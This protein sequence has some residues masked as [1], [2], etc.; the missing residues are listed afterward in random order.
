[1]EFWQALIRCVFSCLHECNDLYLVRI[2]VSILLHSKTDIQAT[3]VP[4][5]ESHRRMIFHPLT[6]LCVGGEGRE[7]ESAHGVFFFFHFYLFMYLLFSLLLIY[8]VCER[9]VGLLRW[10]SLKE[11]SITVGRVTPVVWFCARAHLSSAYPAIERC[12]PLAVCTPSC[13]HVTCQHVAEDGVGTAGL[14]FTSVFITLCVCVFVCSLSITSIVLWLDLEVQHPSFSLCLSFSP[15]CLSIPLHS[16]I[17]TIH[18]HNSGQREG[19]SSFIY[20]YATV[21]CQ[22]SPLS[23]TYFGDPEFQKR[24]VLYSTLT[25]SCDCLVA[26]II[27]TDPHASIIHARVL[28]NPVRQHAIV[29]TSLPLPLLTPLALLPTLWNHSHMYNI[30]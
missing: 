17:K 21:P 30:L 25:L 2:S 23:T 26:V 1:M 3:S 19:W 18:P 20:H 22:T 7:R 16:S 5:F 28:R 15:F 10:P 9:A 11:D 13:V 12:Q 27:S 14:H 24:D 4:T 6:F 29:F 8:C